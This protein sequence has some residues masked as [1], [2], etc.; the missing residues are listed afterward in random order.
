MESLSNLPSLALWSVGGVAFLL[1]AWLFWRLASGVRLPAKIPQRA[2]ATPLSKPEEKRIKLLL[3]KDDFI[4]AAGHYF[5]HR[6]DADAVKIL[7][8]GKRFRDAG[9]F[10]AKMRD[11]KAA[12]AMYSQAGPEAAELAAKCCEDL[13]QAD[14]ARELYREA[15]NLARTSGRWADAAR[16]HERAKEPG[17]AAEMLERV[18]EERRKRGGTPDDESF[19]EDAARAG[20]FYRAAKN[21]RKAAEMYQLGG[22]HRIAGDLL[23]EI[24]DDAALH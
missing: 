22:F 23:T 2:D 18:L 7:V 19:R 11:H 9:D 3:E 10:Y 20:S 21:P 8:R 24:G 16:C 12:L 15:A 5:T 17:P 13:R 14:R 4:A 1:V 6:L